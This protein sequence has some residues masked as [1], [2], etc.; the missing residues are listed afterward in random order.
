MARTRSA[1]RATSSDVLFS[2]GDGSYDLR[3]NSHLVASYTSQALVMLEKGMRPRDELRVTS[4][5]IQLV[6]G[7][8][9]VSETRCR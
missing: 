3:V 2:A 7:T 8:R 9:P 6:G 5:S 1:L 4:D